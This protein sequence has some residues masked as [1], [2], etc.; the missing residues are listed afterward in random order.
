MKLPAPCR[1]RQLRRPWRHLEMLDHLAATVGSQSFPYR[2][3][4]HEQCCAV[5]Y[6]G[7]PSKDRV[8]VVFEHST[9]FGPKASPWLG[10]KQ[11]ERF[12]SI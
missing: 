11:G 2:R 3:C 5:L 1:M 4:G 8:V 10:P 12:D 6:R 7:K 9:N